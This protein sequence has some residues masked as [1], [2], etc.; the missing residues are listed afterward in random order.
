MYVLTFS[1]LALI[2]AG[3]SDIFLKISSSCNNSI[4]IN[5]LRSIGAIVP[6][7]ILIIFMWPVFVS[8]YSLLLWTFISGAFM[9]IAIHFV[10]L[11]LKNGIVGV[12]L[13]I[14]RLAFIVT[15]VV[16]FISRATPVSAYNILGLTCAIC[17]V[18]LLTRS[19]S[20]KKLKSKKKKII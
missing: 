4:R 14:I 13:P 7:C 1:I 10:L 18:F 17:A 5:Y 3:I 8:C 15:F 16:S 6:N 19:D 11:S 20:T 2:F 9:A 12:H